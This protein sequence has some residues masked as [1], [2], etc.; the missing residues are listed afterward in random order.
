MANKWRDEVEEQNLKLVQSV[1]DESI[2]ANNVNVEVLSD[3]DAKEAVSAYIENQRVIKLTGGDT[4]GIELTIILN[5]KIFNFLPEDIKMLAIKEIIHG[6]HRNKQDKVARET[7]DA[8]TSYLGFLQK[9]GTD[10]FVVYK[11][12]LKSAKRAFDEGYIPDERQS[13]MFELTDEDKIKAIQ[14][15]IEPKD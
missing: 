4:D 8:F 2:I 10:K 3:D 1:I 13:T 9:T 5:E 14:H 15:K 11:E 7:D 6:I 12:A